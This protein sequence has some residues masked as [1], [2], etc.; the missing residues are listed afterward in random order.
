M[1]WRPSGLRLRQTPLAS[2]AGWSIRPSTSRHIRQ[3]PV[4]TRSLPIA[5]LLLSARNHATG[6][7]VAALLALGASAGAQVPAPAPAP[8]APA[9]A[10]VPALAAP[11]ARQ[12]AAPQA[13]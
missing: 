2:C 13:V 4:F 12:E 11:A 9:R 7:A 6:W 8:A 10:P 5:P 1:R 3:G